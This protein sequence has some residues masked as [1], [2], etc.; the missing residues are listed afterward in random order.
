M[1]DEFIQAG[2]SASSLTGKDISY[3]FKNCGR[4]TTTS[5]SYDSRLFTVIFSQAAYNNTVTF[6][7]DSRAVMQSLNHT[8]L[9]VSEQSPLALAHS[10]NPETNSVNSGWHEL[11]TPPTCQGSLALEDEQK[12]EWFCGGCHTIFRS[13]YEAKRHIDTAGM[14]T[15]GRVFSMSTKVEGARVDGGKDSERGIPRVKLLHRLHLVCGEVASRLP[16]W[17][18]FAE[19]K[20]RVKAEIDD[21]PA[22]PTLRPDAHSWRCAFVSVI[23]A[24]RSHAFT[25]LPAHP[26]RNLPEL[27]QGPL[28][29]GNR[30][31]ETELRG[32]SSRLYPIRPLRGEG[33]SWPQTDSRPPPH[34][35]STSG[36]GSTVNVQSGLRMHS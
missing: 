11:V 7:M 14:E 6:A 26:L 33:L 4:P 22:K 3:L 17:R 35:P 8:L 1:R 10:D 16:R 32:R 27:F 31:V 2:I 18:S 28:S 25:K 5:A 21:G 30:L 20:F 13:R 34:L 19:P 24:M 29:P 15:R 9:H 12:K 23:S 36:E